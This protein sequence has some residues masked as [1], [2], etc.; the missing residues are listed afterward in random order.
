MVTRAEIIV[1]IDGRSYKWEI[2]IESTGYFAC[3]SSEHGTIL[4]RKILSGMIQYP[5]AKKALSSA[6]ETIWEEIKEKIYELIVT[7]VEDC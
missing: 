4:N 3:F 6:L 5:F 2:H 7:I 1:D